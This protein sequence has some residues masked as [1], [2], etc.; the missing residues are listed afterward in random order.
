MSANVFLFPGVVEKELISFQD[1]EAILL[2]HLEFIQVGND[3]EQKDAENMLIHAR[4]VLKDLEDRRKN[5]L[6]PLKKEM[7]RIN[8]LFKQL[9]DKINTG[10]TG[11]NRALQV[12][13]QEQERI[14]EAKRI[15]ILTAQNA[16]AEALQL[17]GELISV[18][19]DPWPEVNK[20]SYAD[21]G[22]VTYCDDIKIEI[23]D[24]YL[25]PRDLCMPD[26]VKIRARAKSGVRII[27]GVR[28]TEIKVPVTRQA[29]YRE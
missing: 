28:I 8:G 1:R 22:S 26:P 17:T 5:A 4:A 20:T 24:P 9:M 15:E 16:A 23:T 27:P 3:A 29:P 21:L 12:W 13:R 10:V 14:A 11:I 2:K 25:V 18:P 7:K 19:A 6:E